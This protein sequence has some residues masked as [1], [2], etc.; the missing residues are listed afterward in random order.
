MQAYLPSGPNGN[1]IMPIT[2]VAWCPAVAVD[3]L[4]GEVEKLRLF[5]AKHIAVDKLVALLEQQQL[6]AAIDG[7]AAGAD[8]GAAAPERAAAGDADA[9]GDALMQADG[10]DGGNTV[11]AKDEKLLALP[12]TAQV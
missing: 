3:Q 1:G 12:S 4:L 11:L 8:A 7:A 6:Q 10:G 2:S 5:K 9:D